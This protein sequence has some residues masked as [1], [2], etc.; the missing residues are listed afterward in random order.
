MGF[1]NAIEDQLV[2]ARISPNKMSDAMARKQ[3]KCGYCE[4]LRDTAGST[5]VFIRRLI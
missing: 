1:A 4:V 2:S 5:K 3:G